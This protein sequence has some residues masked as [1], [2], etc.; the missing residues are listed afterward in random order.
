MTAIER[1]VEHPFSYRVKDFVFK[2]RIPISN[3][4]SMEEFLPPE[5]DEQGKAFVEAMGNI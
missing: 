1:L 2:F 3:L 5:Y 4:Q